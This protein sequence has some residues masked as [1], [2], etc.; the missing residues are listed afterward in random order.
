ME[1]ASR[2]Q[3]LSLVLVFAVEERGFCIASSV[4]GRVINFIDVELQEGEPRASNGKT[5]TH[6]N[7]HGDKNLYSVRSKYSGC[8]HHGMM[9]Y[10]DGNMR[11]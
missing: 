2:A 1:G 7:V 8:A 6:M 4:S 10:F 9:R 3:L 5:P 11:G